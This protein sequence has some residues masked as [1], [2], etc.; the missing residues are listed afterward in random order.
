GHPC[1]FERNGRDSLSRS[2]ERLQIDAVDDESRQ[3]DRLGF[4]LLRKGVAKALADPRLDFS[5]AEEWHWLIRV[6]RNRAQIIEAVE[7]ICM[8]MGEQDCIESLDLLTEQLQAKLG[9]GV[10]EDGG[11]WRG[12]EDRAAVA[13]VSW[14]GRLADLA[15]AADHG[16]ADGCAGA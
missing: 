10:D 15:A 8:S 16:D 14:I 7:V 9:C 12:D 5:G 1:M 4:R 13:M 11:G 6:L 3:K 2:I